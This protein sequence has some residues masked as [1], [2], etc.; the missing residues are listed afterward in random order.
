[1]G[2]RIKIVTQL[3]VFSQLFAYIGVV[4]TQSNG[5]ILGISE[6]EFTFGIRALKIL[7][8]SLRVNL[9]SKNPFAALYNTI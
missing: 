2:S 9:P 6:G 7:L 4:I 5:A 8:I 1:M 3:H